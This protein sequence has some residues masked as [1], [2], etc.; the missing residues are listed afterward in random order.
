MAAAREPKFTEEDD[1]SDDEEIYESL[2]DRI[3]ALK[4]CTLPPFVNK[5]A[6]CTLPS[7]LNLPAKKCSLNGSVFSTG[8]YSREYTRC[9]RSKCRSCTRR[10]CASIEMG[11]KR[12]LDCH[13][14]NVSSRCPGMFSITVRRRGLAG[15]VCY[16]ERSL[17]FGADTLYAA[18]AGSV[19]LWV[20]GALFRF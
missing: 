18:R 19:V 13:Y 6:V 8:I 20:H 14:I 7:F 2:V 16:G 4:V 11:R 17:F 12:G 5:I 15:A 10:I 3:V 1:I 9:H